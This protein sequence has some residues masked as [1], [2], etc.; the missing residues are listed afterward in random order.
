[1]VLP[2]STAAEGEAAQAEWLR[3]VRR[4]LHL[5]HKGVLVMIRDAQLAQLRPLVRVL[6][7]I[8]PTL[9]LTRHAPELVE[10]GEGALVLLIVEQKD[11]GWLNLNRP[12]FAQRS[13][14]VVLWVEPELSG[15]IKFES[16]DLHDWISH[17][18]P[19]PEGVPEFAVEGL[20][21]GSSWW[22]GVAWR[23]AGLELALGQL[24]LE[25]LTLRP[26]AEFESLVS[27]LAADRRSNVRWVGVDSL[28]ELW[29][30][31]WALADARHHGFCVLDQ[32]SV[33]TPGWFPV[34]SL[35]LGVDDAEVFIEGE[36]QLRRAIELELEPDQILPKQDE[37]VS[38]EV[39]AGL[40]LRPGPLLRRLHASPETATWRRNLVRAIRRDPK[41]DWSRAEV[42]VFASLERDRKWWPNW[43]GQ[44]KLR[45]S[46][47][48]FLRMSGEGI[49]TL[50][51]ASAAFV[52]DPE[53]VARWSKD[54]AATRNL[55]NLGEF[56]DTFELEDAPSV[57]EAMDM[58]HKLG[59]DPPIV[60]RATALTA[61]QLLDQPTALRAFIEGVFTA[62]LA[63]LGPHDRSLLPLIQIAA[64]ATAVAGNPW[65]ARDRLEEV[66][67]EWSGPVPFGPDYAAARTLCG[68][69]IQAAEVLRRLARGDSGETRLYITT[70]LAAGQ[71]E[72]A[73][74]EL[75]RLLGEPRDP[76]D[77]LGDLKNANERARDYL[78]DRLHALAQG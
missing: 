28:R 21:I 23:G 52:H 40:L 10:C 39:E 26:D 69:Y 14:R 63:D 44:P 5:G 16:P 50:I 29:R 9:T 32:P 77:Y 59:W 55:G 47:E 11:L 43:L 36:N 75:E 4:W 27:T 58:G 78:R 67:S 74:A 49:P 6:E 37:F 46:T 56:L 54:E 60:A 68:E 20:R 12:I 2:A 57:D 53:L 38:D 65:E 72:Q 22:P 17:F 66:A 30:V 31:R 42:A 61:E 25:V 18:V 45:H 33:S 51:G 13:L 64:I 76:I 35:Q 73:R 1:M 8:D 15:R 48:H 24:K 71:A 34:S 7:S 41:R 62:A 70:L 19:C 3:Q